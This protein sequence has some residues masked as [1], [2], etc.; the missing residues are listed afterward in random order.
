MVAKL[1]PMSFEILIIIPLL[2]IRYHLVFGVHLDLNSKKVIDSHLI[3]EENNSTLN[4]WRFSN[5]SCLLEKEFS[6]FE[7]KSI[8]PCLQQRLPIIT[9][10][11][12]IQC[13]MV[14]PQV[15]D[16]NQSLFLILTRSPPCLQQRLP[17]I[18]ETSKILP[19]F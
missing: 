11:S 9:E 14:I 3:L 18:T 6:L 5:L 4:F 12:K 17:I 16:D 15:I 19:N 1:Y 8:R 7:F 13:R 2:L 10:T